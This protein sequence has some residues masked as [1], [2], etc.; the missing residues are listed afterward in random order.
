[1]ITIQQAVEEI[2]KKSPYLES[3]LADNL[4]NASAL[5]RQIRGEIENKLIKDVQLGAVTMAIKRLTRKLNKQQTKIS[6]LLKSYGDITVKSNLA[7]FTFINSPS[8]INKQRELLQKIENERGVFLTITQSVFQTTLIISASFKKIVEQIFKD[9]KKISETSNLSAITLTL[10]EETVK[11]PGVYY[12]ILKALAWY[13][14][15]II[16]LVSSFNELTLILE[17]KFIDEAFSILKTR[18]K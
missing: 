17:D 10:S 18:T 1:M 4:I 13:G 7:V 5:A 8:L 11:T 3:A 2:V 9:E 16:E 15:N 12:S 6:P 14:I